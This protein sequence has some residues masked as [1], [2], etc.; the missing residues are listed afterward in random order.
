MSISYL[1]L[2]Q[3]RSLHR[4]QSNLS[5]CKHKHPT[6]DY[7]A[8]LKRKATM[9]HPR[10][11]N[12]VLGSLTPWHCGILDSQSGV[13]VV[14]FLGVGPRVGAAKIFKQDEWCLSEWAWPFS[15]L[16]VP[17]SPSEL[18][19]FLS[20]W[21]LPCT[22]PQSWTVTDATL[23]GLQNCELNNWLVFRVCHLRYFVTVIPR[24]LR[25][26]LERAY[27]RGVRPHTYAKDAKDHWGPHMNLCR[28][29][30]MVYR[31][32]QT[33]EPTE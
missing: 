18:P 21:C 8:A 15:C 11:S 29:R 30:L 6:L 31:I 10:S 25:Q 23:P 17:V 26:S 33:R 32:P 27:R 28:Y 16:S 22:P 7:H 20:L 3:I 2:I 1:S 24:W 13:E 9:R 19:H 5:K 12:R 14:N 4:F